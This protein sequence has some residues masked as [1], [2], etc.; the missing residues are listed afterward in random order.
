MKRLGFVGGVLVVVLVLGVL[1]PETFRPHG[2][3]SDVPRVTQPAAPATSHPNDATS[4]LPS[5][6]IWVRQ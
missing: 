1:A 2:Q 6:S 4:D 5:L 3:L